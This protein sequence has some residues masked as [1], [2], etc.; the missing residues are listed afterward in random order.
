MLAQVEQLEAAGAHVEISNDKAAR[1]VGRLLRGLTPE[2]SPKIQEPLQSVDLSFL[3]VPL[4]AINVGL[5]S[6]M[7]SLSDQDVGVIQVDW[8][9]PGGGKPE[10]L[11]KLKKLLKTE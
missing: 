4:A 11:K 3:Q 1:Y 8:R 5:E 7:E 2:I 6:F 10:I 9:P